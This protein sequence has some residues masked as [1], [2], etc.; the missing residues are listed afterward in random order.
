MADTQTYYDSTLTGPELDAALQKLPQVDEAVKQA[1]Q[2]AILARSWAEGSTGLREEES[3]HNAKYWCEQA[4]TIA[5]G[6]LGWFAD[7]ADLQG[8]YP[9]GQNGQWAI[10]GETDTIWI[11]DAEK[12][13]WVDSGAQVDLSPYYTAEQ[14]EAITPF[15]Y[16][17]T[18]LLDGWTGDGPYTQTVA[19]LPVDDGPAVTAESTMQSPVMIDDTFT[20]DTYDQMNEA[21]SIINAGTKTFGDGTITCTIRESEKP[22]C[23]TEVF[24]LVKKGGA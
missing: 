8:M 15:L 1:E 2:S 9:V 17:A 4:Q 13:A 14:T 22:V 19:V 10:V 7:P 21:G 12:A 20:G 16:R 6:C 18:F 11:W 5:N 24:F 23:D 3:L